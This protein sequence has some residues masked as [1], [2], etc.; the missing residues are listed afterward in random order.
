MVGGAGQPDTR[1]R[2]VNLAHRVEETAKNWPRT[3]SQGLLEDYSSDIYDT[4]P[5]QSVPSKV[6]TAH[7]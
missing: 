4:R 2:I 5:I 7:G 1:R 6:D 3:P